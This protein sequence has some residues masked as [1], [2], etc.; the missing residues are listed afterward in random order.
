MRPST[1][2]PLLKLTILLFAAPTLLSIATAPA[3]P[4]KE[5]RVTQVIN[6][7]KI[8]PSQ[9]AAKPAVVNDEVREGTAV[10]TGTESRTELTFG[11]L[12]IARL[13][14][15]TIFSFDQ[16]TRTIDLGGGAI[17][18]RVPPGSGGAKIKTAA[19]TAAITG[20]TMMAEYHPSSFK[21]IMLEG[22]ATITRPGSPGESVVLKTGQMLAGVPGQRLR[23]PVEVDLKELT[24][25]SLLLQD[26][27]PIGSEGLIERGIEEQQNRVG[28][29]D[30]G[31]ISVVR[32]AIDVSAIDQRITVAATQSPSP[33]PSASPSPTASPTATPTP[34]KF[35]P[36]VVITSPVLSTIDSA[37]SI[38][39]DPTISRN[40]ETGFG[41]IYRGQAEDGAP[42]SYFFGSTSAFDTSS[43]FNT[44]F[45]NASALPIAAFKFQNLQIGGNPLVSTA[46]GGAPNLA[47]ISVGALTSTASAGTTLTFAGIQRL[48]LATQAGSVSLGAQFTFQNLAAL[49]VYA[50][51]A[52][53][54]LRFD[55]S[56][57]GT[58]D[59]YLQ[60]ERDVNITQSLSVS[61]TASGSGSGLNVALRAGRAVSV[62]ANLTLATDASNV[63]DG[64]NVSITAGGNL[65]VGGA[66]SLSTR[67]G[68]AFGNG[69]NIAVDIGGALSAASVSATANFVSAGSHSAGENI[70]FNVAGNFS[71][72]AGGVD[73]SIVTPVRQTVGAGAN[74]ALLVGGN[75][76]LAAGADA[77]FFINNAINEVV[78]GANITASIAGS[79]TTGDFDA[80]V[81]N[82]D[83]EIGTGGNVTVS[84]GGNFSA[85]AVELTLDNTS[86]AIGNGANIT[87]M[88]G[89]NLIADRVAFTVTNAGGSIVTGGNILLDISGS[90]NASEPLAL[91]VDNSNGGVIGNGGNITFR[92]GGN[93]STTQGVALTLQNTSGR[94]DTGGN[95]TAE[96]GGSMS[97]DMFQV[98]LQNW[99]IS[100]NPT[101]RIGTG[102]NINVSIGGNLT[103]GG[104]EILLNNRNGSMIQA[105]GNVILTV[106]GA[107]TTLENRPTAFGP[108]SLL[109]TSN[110]ANDGGA[111]SSIGSSVL[112]QLRAN[113]ASIGGTMNANVSV[114]G[115]TI[116]GDA[117]LDI[118]TANNLAVQGNANLQI[119]SGIAAGTST[120]GTINGNATMLLRAANLS[121]GG[122]FTMSLT[123]AGTIL[124]NAILDLN[125]G[126]VSTGGSSSLSITNSQLQ[127]LGRIG[128]NAAINVVAT[129]IVTN[130]A[131]TS[132]TQQA[133]N[134]SVANG[135]GRI[136]GNARV[137]VNARD[138]TSNGNTIA[139][140]RNEGGSIVGDATN[141]FVARNVS[142]R[143]T[144]FGPGGFFSSVVNDL[145][146]IGGNV[147][148]QLQVTSLTSQEQFSASISNGGGQI[149]GGAQLLISSAGNISST[150]QAN[151]Q[152]DNSGGTI[153]SSAQIALTAA[154]V[155]TGGFFLG[156]IHNVDGSI[157]GAA[158]MSFDVSGI[159]TMQA[160]AL[161]YVFNGAGTIASNAT[162]SLS[163]ADLTVNT[164]PGFRDI[165]QLGIFNDSGGQIG[166]NATINLTT[167]NLTA[168]DILAYI[169]NDEG[170]IGGNASVTLQAA[171]ITVD[172]YLIAFVA[173][174]GGSIGGSTNVLVH[175]SQV[176][177]I[178]YLYVL[179]RVAGDVQ[180][181]AFQLASTDVTSQGSINV[182][183]GG[184]T[185]YLH[186]YS[187][188][189]HE[190]PDVLH[191][192]TAPVVTSL[193][194]IDFE[195]RVNQF[196]TA[197]RQ[198]HGGDLVINANSLSFGPMG[199]IVGRVSF[200]GA[201][202]SPTLAA[203]DGGSFV[204]NTTGAIAV[205]SAI[206]ATTG[207]VQSSQGPTGTGGSVE[208]NSTSGSVSVSARMEVS[209]AEAA[210]TAPRR[211]SARGGNIRLSSG[212]AATPTARAVAINLSNSSQLLA[213]LDAAAPG[214][215]GTITLVATGADTDVNVNGRSEATRGT[216]DI[217]HQGA[218]GR[219]NIGG[220]NASGNTATL[221]ADVVR[222]GAFGANGQLNVGNST[223]SAD[224]LIR[225]YATGSN[226][227]L[228]FVA[229]TTLSSGRAIDLAAGTVTIQPNVIVTIAGNA[230]PANVYTSNP[231]YSG[232]GGTNPMNG[233]FGG[234][235]ANTPQPLSAAPPF[236]APLPPAGAQP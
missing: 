93:L 151:V 17:L 34:S 100:T 107:L 161:F 9:A 25:T 224:S 201:D 143:N 235:G 68:A 75:L 47:L 67:S 45:S 182:R 35:G 141:V 211:R 48:L 230:G 55:S 187:A 199:N 232:F 71:T 205:D 214:P 185:R 119:L 5:A 186:V 195:G 20:T 3:A 92:T 111:A 204:V 212:R 130:T 144:D 137:A 116:N 43:G 36:L 164:R 26:F 118:A 79:M 50:R 171:N 46:N 63:S 69:G 227:E 183:E 109:L 121:S 38:Q 19:V 147:Q 178:D 21:F 203:G 177:D 104:I 66:L 172:L 49:Y 197:S 125:V 189:N 91:R 196:N 215:G 4:L 95:I 28:T 170:T 113:S 194:G 218:R 221:S 22:T 202:S 30:V 16:G 12:S 112:V 155:T 169:D 115:S 129:D 225:L 156:V 39:T 162:M 146:I 86:G 27:G 84:S 165:L 8:L 190:I 120:G 87:A 10:R 110:S 217:R 229:N 11:D 73:L 134:F 127:V 108:A 1:P 123:N 220:T 219:V 200:N 142:T 65:S 174:A 136:D 51:G 7:V 77:I 167:G 56:V 58:R 149:G 24:E 64:G 175:A 13:G 122:L 99:D 82:R 126:T 105:G 145:G 228:N 57:S 132:A 97:A 157:Q 150:Q 37:T 53:S 128:G 114:R 210:T 180:V 226:G 102:G 76:T 236:D 81:S 152:I 117:T 74:I 124:Q 29:T 32:N 173:N 188:G 31:V 209:S 160:G 223:V 103:A 191:T 40:G 41:R 98:L 78:T 207:R 72:T 59:F 192:L 158:T 88:V 52:A 101:G 80:E 83:G 179:G 138:T 90:L 18:L 222:A 168:G 14:A 176:I 131:L 106:A 62:G 198:P 133:L 135:A 184:I 89:G 70:R 231:N 154:S 33:S 85:A 163:A 42:S 181:R 61:Q 140:I 60:A 193:A 233:T 2:I 6:D 15:N 44:F 166:G 23:Q 216:V 148:L 234:N 139:E 54:D 208:L 153:G 159:A 213:L 94:I 96:I 206:E